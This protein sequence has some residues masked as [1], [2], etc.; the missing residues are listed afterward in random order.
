M[1]GYTIMRRIPVI[2]VLA[3]LLLT[4]TGCDFFRWVAGRPTAAQLEQKR[5]AVVAQ[6]VAD[7]LAQERERAV[8]DSLAALEKHQTDS[9]AA[10]TFFSQHRV[11][12][13]HSR[14]LPGLRLEDIPFRY[15]IVLAGFSQ[16]GNAEK[17]A[18][19]LKEA[20]Y[21]SV[22]M[23]YTRGSNAIVGVCPTDHF[24]DLL[25]VY[26]RVRTEKFCPKDAWIFIKD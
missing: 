24:G 20:G 19:S 14:S 23:K 4:V 11:T 22:V 9:V 12:R 25:D 5:A 7:Q 26:Q 16:P 1:N 18:D 21:E 15:C 17:F 6:A 2:C 10:E 8:R 3:I 13:I